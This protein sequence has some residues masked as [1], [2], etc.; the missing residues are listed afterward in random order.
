M[1]DE[2]QCDVF[3]SHS[4]K[5]KAASVINGIVLISTRGNPKPGIWKRKS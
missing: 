2:F 5:D 1:L 4:K 3:L